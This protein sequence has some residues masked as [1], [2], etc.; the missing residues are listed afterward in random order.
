MNR[1]CL[2]TSAYSHFKRSDPKVVELIDSAA[3]VG[4]PSV[5]LG[6]LEVGFQLGNPKRLEQNRT[7][8]QEFLDHPVVEE[9]AVDSEVTPLY[10]ELVISLRKAGTPVPTNDIWIGALAVRA[11]ATVLTY[12]DH[13]KAMQRVGSI[14][15]PQPAAP[16]KRRGRK[17]RA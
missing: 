5:V 2:D 13:F 1:Y 14:I 10:A 15:L 16:E 4:V 7:E 17:P 12:D 3:W 11:G 9:L 8:V 6:G